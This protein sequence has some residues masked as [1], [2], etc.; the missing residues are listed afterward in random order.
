MLPLSCLVCFNV[1]LEFL[2]CCMY[3]IFD[4]GKWFRVS[5]TGDS[6]GVYSCNEISATVFGL[7]ILLRYS[8]LTFSFVSF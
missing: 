8:L 7:L 2:N 1:V 5:Y 3:A 6:L 4:T